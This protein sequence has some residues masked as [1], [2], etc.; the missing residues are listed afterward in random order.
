M[1]GVASGAG[2]LRLPN[3]DVYEGETCCLSTHYYSLLTTHYSLLGWYHV[4]RTSLIA[5]CTKTTSVKVR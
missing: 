4:P 1:Q 2:R 3:R 5:T